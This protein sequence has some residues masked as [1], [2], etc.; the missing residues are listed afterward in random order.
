MT[1]WQEGIRQVAGQFT[2]RASRFLR[3]WR[4][5]LRS[6]LPLRWQWALG[7]SPARLLLRLDEDALLAYSDVAG[8]DSGAIRLPWPCPPAALEAALPPRLRRLPRFWLLPVAQVLQRRM[9][10]PAAAAGRLHD[11]VGFEIDRQ[12]PFSADQVVYDVRVLGPV[13]T[14]QL[15]VELVVLPRRQLDQWQEQAG[16]WATVLAGLDVLAAPGSDDAGVPLRVNLL[17]P[18][19]RH[20]SADPQRRRDLLL[21]ATAV[22]LLGLAGGRILDNRQE[23]ANG[24]RAQVQD[25]SRQARAVSDQRAELQALVDGARF[26]EE[27]RARQPSSLQV[28]NE[29][30]RLLP[31]G[32]YLEKIGIENGTV[33]LIGLSREASQLV[34]LLQ[35]S[36]LWQRVNLTGVLQADQAAG[37]DRFTLT[38]ELKAPAPAQ[39]NKE[40]A[41]ADRTDRP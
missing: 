15:E 27:R 38:A 26:L 9:R 11:V 12:T 39:A 1:A 10:L 21:L 2:P 3:W 16:E 24:L 23:A 25:H 32:T 36:P 40:A 31:T 4:D 33:Q 30:S 7:W 19:Q 28:W 5:S 29:L 8:S 22:V 41:H 37:R 17:P 18:A 14:A 6:W 13:G 34:P 20:R 35:P